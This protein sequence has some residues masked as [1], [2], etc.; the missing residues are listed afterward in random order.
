MSEPDRCPE[1]GNPLALGARFCPRC[2]AELPGYAL[3]FRER[4]GPP[5]LSDGKRFR[6][7]GAAARRMLYALLIS[8]LISMPLL[9]VFPDQASW[10]FVAQLSMGVVVLF[11]AWPERQRILPLYRFAPLRW[12]GGA[13]VV[14]SVPPLLASSVQRSF[15]HG[16]PVVAHPAAASPLFLALVFCILPA[17]IEELAFRGVILSSLMDVF[18][19]R[20]AQVLTALLFAGAHLNPIGFPYLFLLGLFLGW[21]RLH[22]RSLP[23]PVLAHALHNATIL[24]MAG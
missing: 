9:G 5:P 15:F 10:M 11:C 20:H 21:L 17:L 14:G 7:Q 8:L 16:H 18:R 23:V 22:S 12:W 3:W 4:E 24:L 1:C 13:L 19:S 6:L 2:G